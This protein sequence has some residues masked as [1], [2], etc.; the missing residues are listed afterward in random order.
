MADLDIAEDL[1]A[2][3]D[4]HAMA[5]FRMAVLVLLAGAAERDVMQDRDVVVDHR[6]LAHHQTGG[7]VEEDAAADFGRR[8]DVALERRRGTALQIEREILAALA[9]EPMRQPMGLDGVEALVVEHRLDEAAGRRI[10]VEGGDDVGAED[11][12]DRRLIVERVAIGLADQVAGHV[13]IAE[14]FA[15]AVDHRRFQRVVV[16][17]VLVDEGG[18]LRLAARDVLRLTA[19]ARPDRIDLVEA[20]GRPRLKLSHIGSPVPSSRTPTWVF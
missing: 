5:D 17:D 19:D 16:Q 7:V 20:L 14:P 9:V 12:A 15:D 13:G 8:I 2:G 4:H 6:G 1:G 18:K 3:A 11:F 10:A